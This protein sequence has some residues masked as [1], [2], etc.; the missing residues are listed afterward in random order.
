MRE[1]EGELRVGLSFDALEGLSLDEQW[2]RMRFLLDSSRRPE[3]LCPCLGEAAG[4]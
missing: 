1:H 2:A 3:M 4:G